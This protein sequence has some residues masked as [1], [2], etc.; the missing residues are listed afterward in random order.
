VEKKIFA[1]AQFAGAKEQTTNNNVNRRFAGCELKTAEA[2][3]DDET[4]ERKK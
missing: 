4:T 1:S 2:E 3:A